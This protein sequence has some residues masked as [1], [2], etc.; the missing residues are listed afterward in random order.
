MYVLTKYIRL[1][2]CMFEFGPEELGQFSQ[3]SNQAG[4][5]INGIRF[6][7]GTSKFLSF[8]ASRLA[9]GPTLPP[10]QWIRGRSNLGTKASG[11]QNSP[12]TSF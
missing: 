2:V 3:F 10:V 4:G 7:A 5:Q 12:L 6:P 11:A 9:L 8:T 1:F